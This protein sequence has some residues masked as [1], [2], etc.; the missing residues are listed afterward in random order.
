MRLV[1]RRRWKIIT[2][3]GK[4][5]R[6]GRGKRQNSDVWGNLREIKSK[7]NDGDRDDEEKYKQIHKE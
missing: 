4:R 1:R 3:R 6:E 2:H 7:K 5:M